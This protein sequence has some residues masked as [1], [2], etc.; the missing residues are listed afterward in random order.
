ME[1]FRLYK[2]GFDWRIT[3]NDIGYLNTDQQKYEMVVKE[4]E[5]LEK[6]YSTEDSVRLSS[7]EILVELEI[8]TRQ[9]LSIN[10]VGRQLKN[11]GFQQKS[12]RMQDG[13]TPKKWAVT[14]L[15]RDHT[16]APVLPTVKQE[17]DTPF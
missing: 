8:L 5:L 14:R 6:Y 13:T 1:A 9:K 17:E 12:T 2:E 15:N 3:S 11:M 16:P 4:K 7:T 10:T